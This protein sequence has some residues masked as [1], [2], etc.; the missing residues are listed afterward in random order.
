[1]DL[2]QGALPRRAHAPC[3]THITRPTLINMILVQS[4]NASE[5]AND[6]PSGLQNA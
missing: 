6:E 2:I 3:L 4:P 5:M 1:M